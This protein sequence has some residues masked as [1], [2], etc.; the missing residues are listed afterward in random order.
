M[1]RKLY[2]F[3]ASLRW[4]RLVGGQWRASVALTLGLCVGAA[5]PAADGQNLP[6]VEQADKRLSAVRNFFRSKKSPLD[7][8][9]TDFVSAADRYGLDW[10]L[11][12]ALALI[13]SGG[14]KYYMRNNVF[15]WD[16]GR[17]RFRSIQESIAHIASRLATMP[18]YK[19]KDLRG[20]LRTYN[21][22]RR[23]YPERVLYVIRQIAPDPQPPLAVAAR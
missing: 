4:R 2:S 3:F 12:P 8:Y 16:S 15:G 23:D 10:R 6:P 18:A 20:I 21:P 13:E 9:A 22:A 5:S 17:A 14:G 1:K 11:L 7:K 19:G